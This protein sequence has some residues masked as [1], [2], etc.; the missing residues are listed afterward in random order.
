MG[1]S[2]VGRGYHG[3]DAH[4]RCNKRSDITTERRVDKIIFACEKRPRKIP[5]CLYKIA[6]AILT[7]GDAMIPLYSI[8]NN[9]QS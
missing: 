5:N 9:A 3:L 7:T 1:W 4:S 2:H 8:L 6:P